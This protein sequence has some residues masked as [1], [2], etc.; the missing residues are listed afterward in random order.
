MRVSLR[1]T[2]VGG[3]CPRRPPDP[4]PSN[5]PPTHSPGRTYVILRLWALLKPAKEAL[6]PMTPTAPVSPEDRNRTLTDMA[7]TCRERAGQSASNWH[8]VSADRRLATLHRG[9]QGPYSSP[10][11]GAA[12]A[13]PSSQVRKLR[14]SEVRELGAGGRSKIRAQVSAPCAW[15]LDACVKQGAPSNS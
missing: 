10:R 4:W 5:K 8:P 11:E 9:P 1:V 12:G 14:L 7:V 6:R 3:G 15:V 2:G 13:A